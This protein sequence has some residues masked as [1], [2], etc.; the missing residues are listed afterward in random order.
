[1]SQTL[2]AQARNGQLFF[3][4]SEDR[5][6]FPLEILVDE[7]LPAAR[8]EHFT[9]TTGAFRLEAPTGHLIAA[10]IEAW[11]QPPPEARLA[12]APG[13]YLLTVYSRR[14]FDSKRHQQTRAQLLS[15]ADLRYLHRVDRLGLTGCA[16]LALAT[17]ILL[18]PTLRRHWPVATLLLLPWLT[19]LAATQLPRYRRIRSRLSEH[20]KQLPAYVLALRRSGAAEEVAGGWVE[21]E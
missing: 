11:H 8:A 7:P 13:S 19:Y 15:P 16:T 12:V 10:G 4:E 3:I 18:I 6:D 9:T 1:M 5:L 20:E 2:E 14:E 21:C 17:P